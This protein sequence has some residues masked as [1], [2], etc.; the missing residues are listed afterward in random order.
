MLKL[1]RRTVGAILALGALYLGAAL[2][3]GF[4]PVNRDFTETPGGVPIAVCSNGVHT[5]FVLPVKT[6]EVDWSE[7]FPPQHYPVDVTPFDHVGIGWGDL[8]F[9]R[10]TPT[11]ADF[12]I[13]TALRALTGLG[14]AALHVQYRPGPGASEDCRQTTISIPQYRA[15][16]DYIGTTMASPGWPAS[17]GY[18]AT[19][20]FYAAH[21][22]FSLLKSCNVWVGEGL[23]AAGLP[24]ALWTPFAF[25]VLAQF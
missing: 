14:P 4:I 21:G 1:L 6:A 15:L 9:Y 25:Q 11:W 24:S 18:G 12:D 7:V 20:L 10:T 22:R 8:D 19:D 2:A 13:G 23:K 5:D 17:P 3:L 16:S